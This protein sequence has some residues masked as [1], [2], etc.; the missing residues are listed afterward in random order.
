MSEG[1]EMMILACLVVM[2]VLVLLIMAFVTAN[3]DE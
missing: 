1:Q 3:S 2:P